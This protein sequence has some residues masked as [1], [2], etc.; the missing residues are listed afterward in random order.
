MTV[1]Y[2]HR[3]VASERVLRTEP[4]RLLRESDEIIHASAFPVNGS[5]GGMLKALHTLPSFTLTPLLW[6]WRALYA[7]PGETRTQRREA[8]GPKFQCEAE[9]GVESAKRPREGTQA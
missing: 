7:F 6:G 5:T 1:G 3:E 4:E 8:A 2:G 9:A